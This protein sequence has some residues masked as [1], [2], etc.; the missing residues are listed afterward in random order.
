MQWFSEQWSVYLRRI[1]TSCFF[2]N[3][4]LY[5]KTFFIR[6]WGIRLYTN[7]YIL[8]NYNLYWQ[9]YNTHSEKKI[10]VLFIIIFKFWAALF[11][12]FF[13]NCNS[14]TIKIDPI[15]LINIFIFTLFKKKIVSTHLL[16]QWRHFRSFL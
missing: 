9:M 8:F 11:D 2:V 5:S 13:V 10:V 4:Y 14:L 6:Y 1:L 15:R 7:T 16:L 12:D 3:V